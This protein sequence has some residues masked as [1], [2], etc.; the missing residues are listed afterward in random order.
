VA[1]ELGNEPVVDAAEVERGALGE[2]NRERFARRQLA[3]G[4]GPVDLADRRFVEPFTRRRRVAREQSGVALIERGDLEPRELFDARRNDPLRVA[5]REEREVAREVL[6][7]Q[8][9]EIQRLA[10][11]WQVSAP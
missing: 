6:G 9:G 2:L 10:H 3:L 5:R 1:A 8:C 7:D 11:G 4:C